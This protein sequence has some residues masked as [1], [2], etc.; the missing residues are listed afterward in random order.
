MLGLVD[1]CEAARLGFLWSLETSKARDALAEGTGV[2]QKRVNSAA[3]GD[4]TSTN[5]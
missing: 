2:M 3:A 1:I 5:Q 4:L